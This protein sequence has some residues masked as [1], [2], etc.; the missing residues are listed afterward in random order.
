MNIECA[1]CGKN[2]LSR[3]EIGINRKLNKPNTSVFYCLPCLAE[4]LET[5]EDTLEDMIQRFKED[6]CTLFG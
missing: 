2:P 4:Y 5:D 3:D 6:G 1:L